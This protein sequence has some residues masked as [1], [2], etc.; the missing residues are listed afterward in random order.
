MQISSIHISIPRDYTSSFF[1]NMR[2]N[3]ETNNELFLK[4]KKNNSE[5]C[6]GLCCEGC[7]FTKC[8]TWQ[9]INEN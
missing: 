6:D 3:I 8:K 4:N 5:C 7:N 1:D 9:R 2:H